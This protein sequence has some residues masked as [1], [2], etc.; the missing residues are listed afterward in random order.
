MGAEE[1]KLLPSTDAGASRNHRAGF[2]LHY[3]PDIPLEDPDNIRTCAS[4]KDKFQRV[5]YDNHNTDGADLCRD[6]ENHETRPEKS[7]KSG[8]R[9]DVDTYQKG[10]NDGLEKGAADGEKAGFERASKK[11]EPLLDS[12]RSAL[13]QLKTIRAETYH[14]IEKEVVE[15]ALAIARKVVCR[16]IETGREVVL[17]VA[18]EALARIEDPG[19][20][21][22]KMNP[23][24]LQF[25]NETKHQ[26]SGLI[27]SMD[28]VS[29]EAEENIQS[30]GCIIETNFGEIDARIENQIQAVEESFRNAIENFGR[31]E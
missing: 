21:K 8:G 11:L 16:E 25:V 23:A 31:K 30:G 26:L 22:I 1:K 20:I 15:L 6:D 10:F 28:N 7:A 29:F 9:F 19:E 2:R 12:L 24:D 5:R 3:F 27:G 4:L 18:R 13:L 17:G 14:H